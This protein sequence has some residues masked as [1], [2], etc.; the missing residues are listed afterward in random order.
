MADTL[1]ELTALPVSQL[2][3]ARQCAAVVLLRF[4]EAQDCVTAM[5]HHAVQVHLH[6]PE[7]ELV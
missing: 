6:G 5:H 2:P 3:E 1:A 4:A 7:K